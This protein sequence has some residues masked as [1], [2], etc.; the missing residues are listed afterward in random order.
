MR[1][2]SVR[3][4]SQ[5]ED[6]STLLCDKLADEVEGTASPYGTHNLAVYST[7]RRAAI[8]GYK[9]W[10]SQT[11]GTSKSC[12]DCWD[13]INTFN[14]HLAAFIYHFCYHALVILY[15]PNIAQNKNS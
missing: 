3:W 13:I 12:H 9:H 1:Y 8:T 6:V 5:A 7:N 14:Y 10:L 2:E 4:V 11:P 15:F